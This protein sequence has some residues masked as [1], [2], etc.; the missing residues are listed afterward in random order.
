MDSRAIGVF[1]SGVGGLTAVKALRAMLPGEDIVYFGD[2]GRMPY[3]GRPVEEIKRIG[4]QDAAFVESR[5]V[6]ALLVACGTIGSNALEE[7]AASTELPVFS[8]VLPA[9]KAAAEATESGTIAVIATAAAARAGAYERAIKALRPDSDVISAG[10]PLLAPMV[11]SGRIDPGDP[12]VA[13]A[14]RQSLLPVMDRGADVLLLGCTHYPL[15]IPAIRECTGG[16]FKLIDSGEQGARAMLE[17]LERRG[18]LCGKK[19]G[20]RVQYYTS[21]DTAAFERTASIFLREDIRG[22]ARYVPPMPL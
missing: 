3:G 8:V 22:A 6:K 2:T 14:V 18:G 17:Y 13:S 12:E 7:V 15:L 9:A 4:I 19:S 11:E 20:G 16:C 21:G 5:G 10:A 1:D